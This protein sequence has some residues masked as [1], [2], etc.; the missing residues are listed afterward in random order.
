ML[1]FPPDLAPAPSE[2]PP[3]VTFRAT[4]DG[5]SIT[6]LISEDALQQ[7]FGAM[8]DLLATYRENEARIQAAAADKIDAGRWMNTDRIN[9]DSGDFNDDGPIVLPV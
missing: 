5:R 8:G 3:G 7:V 4:D 6:C 9:L 2:D 1:E